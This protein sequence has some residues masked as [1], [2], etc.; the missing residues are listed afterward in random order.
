MRPTRPARAT[1]LPELPLRRK[2]RAGS[3]PR[4][5]AGSEAPSG[6]RP[7]SSGSAGSRLNP[8]S[9]RFNRM[10]AQRLPA[11][12]DAGAH[13]RQRGSGKQCIGRGPGQRD[14][15]TACAGLL[16]QPLQPSAGAEGRQLQGE[17]PHAQQMRCQ[18]MSQLVQHEHDYAHGERTPQP[19][20]AHRGH[21]DGQ[22][23]VR[24]QHDATEG[25][26][27]HRCATSRRVQALA[28]LADFKGQLAIR[29][30]QR[31]AFGD[32]VPF[33]RAACAKAAIERLGTVRMQ[34]AQRI[35]SRRRPA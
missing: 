15:H 11:R 13:A 30:A 18:R 31:I 23:G 1:S 7:P 5:G 28:A 24:L 19:L 27:L 12:K 35:A 21:E 25:A 22:G 6:A 9:S 26:Y 34:K 20:R 4:P 8:I 17:H 16:A 14:G 10:K 29:L 2:R 3:A 32:D 33:A